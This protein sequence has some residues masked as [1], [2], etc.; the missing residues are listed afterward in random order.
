MD[1]PLSQRI[2]DLRQQRKANEHAAAEDR[3]RKERE[4]LK[5]R[6]E[7]VLRESQLKLKSA[8]LARQFARWARRNHI[9]MEHGL[10]KGLLGRWE[11]ASIMPD[12]S[13][14][15]DY[16]AIYVTPSKTYVLRSGKI[17]GQIPP[18]FED[19]IASFVSRYD[20]PWP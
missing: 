3:R 16:G 18:N 2:N 15:T 9:P 5:R 6:Q 20:Y 1:D 14:Y 11:V 17:V 4:G 13:N 7:S 10:A 19:I 8:A 12:T